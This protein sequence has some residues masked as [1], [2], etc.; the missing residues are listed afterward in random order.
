[1]QAGRNLKIV[2]RAGA[3]TDNID[4]KA[5]TSSGVVVM[6][7]PGGNTRSAAELTVSLMLSLARH[8]P[9]SVAALKEGRWT[10]KEHKGTE[11]KGKSIA[12][13]GVGAIGKEVARW[14]QALG[15]TVKGFDPALSPADA[16][17][18][19][20]HK[21]DSLEE[22]WGSADVVSLHV[23]GEGTDGMVG[24]AQLAAMRKGGLLIN[25]ARGKVIDTDALLASLNE[26][27]LGGVAL[28]VYPTEPPSQ[29]LAPLLTHPKVVCT[30]HLGASTEEA[31][32]KVAVDIAQQMADAFEGKAWAGVVNAPHIALAE[33]AAA[34]PLV[35]LAQAVGSLAAQVASA[36]AKDPITHCRVQLLGTPFNGAGVSAAQAAAYSSLMGAAAARGFVPATRPDVRAEDLNLVSAAHRAGDYGIDVQVEALDP[37][38]EFAA[39]TP[40]STLEHSTLVRVPA[41]TKSGQRR[42][43]AGAMEQGKPKI[44]QVDHWAN[45]PAFPPT[46]HVLLLNNMDKPGAVAAVTAQLA[47]AQLNIAFLGVARQSQGAPALTVAVTDAKVPKPLLLRLRQNPDVFNVAAASF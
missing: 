21:L 38:A 15:M 13:V 23:P 19:G 30:P 5:A 14:C 1:M 12:I 27:H 33:T 39:D 28:D 22:V 17:A 34:K 11:L 25:V 4:K 3:G 37:L 10:R 42:V 43:V 35:V 32:V 16:Q 44:V 41:T 6:N 26:G 20:I 36:D 40:A 45:F 7:T 29:A 24:A 18:L 9:Q 8:V 2:G 31:Q 47:E 46:G